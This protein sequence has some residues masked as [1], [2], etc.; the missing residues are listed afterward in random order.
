METQ[1]FFGSSCTTIQKLK[2]EGKLK[3][4]SVPLHAPANSLSHHP[5]C[6]TGGISMVLWKN[7]PRRTL[8]PAFIII[9]ALPRPSW[10]TRNL[11][12]ISPKEDTEMATCYDRRCSMSQLQKWNQHHNEISL[13]YHKNKNIRWQSLARIWGNW[14]THA[15][16][17]ED[18]IV[19]PPWKANMEDDQITK[20]KKLLNDSSIPLLCIYP[21]MYSQ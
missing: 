13:R 19:M 4:F 3:W 16:L 11:I 18:R 2:A 17:I 7:D 10:E 21:D 15:L 8:R 14:T 12:N 9:W 20:N 5:F 1:D 6:L